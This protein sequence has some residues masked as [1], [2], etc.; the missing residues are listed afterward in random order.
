[1]CIECV[2]CGKERDFTF[3]NGEYNEKVSHLKGGEEYISHGWKVLKLFG[4]KEFKDSFAWVCPSCRAGLP[5]RKKDEQEAILALSEGHCP[6]HHVIEL[7]IVG[8][9]GLCPLCLNGWIVPMEVD[10]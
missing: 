7:T 6:V 3:R 1:M 4:E 2:K 8:D 9:I 10:A 5:E